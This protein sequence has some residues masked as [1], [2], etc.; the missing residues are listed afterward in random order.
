MNNGP[1][2]VNYESDSINIPLGK[3]DENRVEMLFINKK[4]CQKALEELCV[5][6]IIKLS[7]IMGEKC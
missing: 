3:M 2:R 1:L 5:A 7:K 4:D 6:R